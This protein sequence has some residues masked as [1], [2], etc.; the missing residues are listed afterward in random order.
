M[1][2]GWVKAPFT[3]DQFVW[4]FEHRISEV[5]Q[6]MHINVGMYLA[7]DGDIKK[8]P[9]NYAIGKGW[10]IKV[11]ETQ[12]QDPALWSNRMNWNVEI[13]DTALAEMFILKFLYL[14]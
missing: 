3:T 10:R 6:W 9:Y 4:P 7:Y 1:I 8:R 5:T 12:Q 14:Y 2:R 11:T 13:D